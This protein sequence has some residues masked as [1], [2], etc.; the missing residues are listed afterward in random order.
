MPLLLGLC[1]LALVF[2]TGCSK[3]AS[4]DK[5]YRAFHGSLAK[6]A[7]IGH[8]AYRAQAFEML[9]EDSKKRLTDLADHVNKTLPE[10]VPPVEPN[11]M[12]QVAHVV[13][14]A[15]ITSIE[16]DEAGDGQVE[17][18]A[19][20]GDVTSSVKMRLEEGKWRVVLFAPAGV[21]E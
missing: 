7:R 10:G 19:I 5:T 15:P 2:Q 6:Y 16:Y 14:D 17:V 4:P 21:E 8:P 18:R 13:L 3:K 9:T 1:L 20:V 12:L 11:E